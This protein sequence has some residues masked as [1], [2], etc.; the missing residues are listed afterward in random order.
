MKKTV[1]YPIQAVDA[2]DYMVDVCDGE[3]V[4]II[5]HNRELTLN[6]WQ[7]IVNCLNEA[8]KNGKFIPQEDFN[9]QLGFKTT[10]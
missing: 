2:G 7:F 6:Q 8:A 1:R 4:Y 3:G 5:Y 9:F 10:K